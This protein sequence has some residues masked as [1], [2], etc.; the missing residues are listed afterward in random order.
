MGQRYS[1]LEI[2]ELS[3]EPTEIRNLL[4]SQLSILINS[5]IVLFR[6]I[7]SYNDRSNYYVKI[8]SKTSHMRFLLSYDDFS[9]LLREIMFELSSPYIITE[10]E[11]SRKK[12]LEVSVVQIFD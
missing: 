10:I 2:F 7:K 12:Y 6:Y 3:Q 9:T 8:K 11:I 1:H 5:D 4:K